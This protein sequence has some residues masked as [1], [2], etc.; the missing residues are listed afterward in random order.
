MDAVV[1]CDSV[2]AF[3]LVSVNIPDIPYTLH[4]S[5]PPDATSEPRTSLDCQAVIE[6]TAGFFMR[7]LSGASWLFIS[8][9]FMQ[10]KYCFNLLRIDQ[11]FLNERNLFV[12]EFSTNDFISIRLQRTTLTTN[13]AY[14]ELRSTT[15]DF[16]AFDLKYIR[17]NSTWT[18]G[19]SYETSILKRFLKEVRSKHSSLYVLPSMSH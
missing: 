12:S 7:T 11:S 6:G 13:P 15:K 18:C 3:P 8:D 5:V 19:I 1:I 10:C 16:L 4:P 9:I 14:I 17:S 2:I